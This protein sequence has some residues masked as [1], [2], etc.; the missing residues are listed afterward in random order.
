MRRFVGQGA[1]G[2]GRSLRTEG[3]TRPREIVD[4]RMIGI[5]VGAFARDLIAFI[6]RM[7]VAPTGES[8]HTGIAVGGAEYEGHTRRQRVVASYLPRISRMLREGYTCRLQVVASCEKGIDPPYRISMG[9]PHNRT[10]R[11]IGLNP[12]C[13]DINHIDDMSVDDLMVDGPCLKSQ[14]LTVRMSLRAGDMCHNS[15][16]GWDS[17]PPTEGSSSLHPRRAKIGVVG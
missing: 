2:A 13:T 4:T 1:H 12:N 6:D 5:V 17:R 14:T 8:S 9:C 11:S 3:S 7:R 16:H 15:P 10:R